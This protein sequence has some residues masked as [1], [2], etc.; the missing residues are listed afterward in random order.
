MKNQ[1]EAV[2]SQFLELRES[3]PEQALR[4]LMDTYGDAMNGIVVK[5]LNRE[6]LIE[7]ALQIGFTKIWKNL[8]EYSPEKSSIFTWLLSIFRNT[9]IDILRKENNRKIQSIDSSVYDSVNFSV[10][11]NII[12]SG[13]MQ[14]INSLDP[15]YKDLIEL[16]YLQGYTQ[17]EVSEEFNIPLGTI[18]TRIS[19]AI[20]LLRSALNLL[21]IFIL[22]R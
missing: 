20:K 22:A 19:T 10:Q 7:D 4:L 13:L 18:K 6:D 14:K 3:K 16:I 1:K 8:N 9:A 17:Q 15:K 12:D 5:I 21:I 11:S 2:L